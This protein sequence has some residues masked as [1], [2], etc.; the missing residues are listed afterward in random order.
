MN[1]ELAK[2]IEKLHRL[3]GRLFVD[4]PDFIIERLPDGRY[5]IKLR[6]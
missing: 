1:P 2:L 3:F 6:R 5:Q 4:S